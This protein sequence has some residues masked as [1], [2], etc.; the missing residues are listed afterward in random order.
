MASRHGIVSAE[1]ASDLRAVT[2][3]VAS[4]P[5]ELQRL[6]GATAGDQLSGAWLDELAK[7]PAT[8]PQR[9]FI[10]ADARAVP[11]ASGLRVETGDG[12]LARVFEFG[13]NNQDATNTYYRRRNQ[14]TGRGGMVTRRT[15]RQ[16]PTRRAGGYI[17][18]PAAN[19]FGTRAFSMWAQLIRKVTH[20][21]MEGK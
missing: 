19:A 11:F 2:R 18:Y 6:I 8:A 4:A 21:W 1:A 7:R 17:A 12:E 3:A 16:I 14:R 9:K 20:D 15:R 10:L 5:Q 13:T